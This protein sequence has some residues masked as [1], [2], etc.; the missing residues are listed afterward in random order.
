[1]PLKLCQ[2]I[3][4]KDGQEDRP[5]L[6]TFVDLLQSSIGA[7]AREQR[8]RSSAQ[9]AHVGEGEMTDDAGVLSPAPKAEAG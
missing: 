9:L 5:L 1:M 3:I 8:R 6:A 7:L 4:T 2:V